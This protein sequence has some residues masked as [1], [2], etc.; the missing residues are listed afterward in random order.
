MKRLLSSGL[1]LA[2]WLS[3]VIAGFAIWERYEGTPGRSD[4]AAASPRVDRNGWEIVLFAHPCCPCTRASLRELAELASR[5]G[6]EVTIRV[7][8]PRPEGVPEGWEQTDLW[9]QAA[10]IPGARVSCDPTG[11]EARSAGTWT[12]GQVII[13]DPSGRVAFYG[14]LTRGRGQSGES[15]VREEILELLAGRKTAFQR[16][17]VFGCE[18]FCPV[19]ER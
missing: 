6:P 7:V 2:A 8:F 10:A 19:S 3:L 11:A 12:S 18:L 14:G 15:P 5:A 16:A 1:L 4:C 17:P 13:Y 9:H